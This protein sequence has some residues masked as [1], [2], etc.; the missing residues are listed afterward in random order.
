MSLKGDDPIKPVLPSRINPT[1]HSTAG[2]FLINTIAREVPRANILEHF[3]IDRKTGDPESVKVE[4]RMTING[5]EVDFEKSIN[6]MWER[7]SKTFDAAVLDKARD[8][9]MLT[10]HQDILDILRSAERE[11]L[12]ELEKHFPNF[13][14]EELG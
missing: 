10:K 14:K 2:I 1:D 9:V 11:L 7:L 4:V 6:D 3:R 13:K 5:V 12:D 8:L